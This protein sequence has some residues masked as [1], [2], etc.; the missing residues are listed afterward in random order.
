MEEDGASDEGLKM[1]RTTRTVSSGVR[2]PY[3]G[4]M[5]LYHPPHKSERTRSAFPAVIHFIEDAVAGIV[6]LTVFRGEGPR[7]ERSVRF[8]FGPAEGRW[9]HRVEE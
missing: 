4:E 7:V 8:A 5:V 3:L 2:A 1:P 9:T 6:D